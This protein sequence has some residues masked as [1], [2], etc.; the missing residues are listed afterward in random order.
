MTKLLP[1][2]DLPNGCRKISEM[3]RN[4]ICFDWDAKFNLPPNGQSSKYRSP[5]PSQQR[6]KK[7]VNFEKACAEDSEYSSIASDNKNVDFV[8]SLSVIKSSQ[9]RR[10]SA[11]TSDRGV[12]KLDVCRLKKTPLL[13]TSPVIV[14]PTWLTASQLL[15]DFGNL[16]YTSRTLWLILS[17][18]KLLLQLPRPPRHLIPLWW[19]PLLVRNPVRHPLW[20]LWNGTLMPTPEAKRDAIRNPTLVLHLVAPH[21]PLE[22]CQHHLRSVMLRIQRSIRL[23]VPHPLPDRFP[24]VCTPHPRRHCPLGCGWRSKRHHKG[25]PQED[26]H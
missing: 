8:D 2:L 4:G 7:S 11:I 21:T 24:V 14:R 25:G 13:M 20:M 3:I 16:K 15:P 18:I 19:P 26:R 10:D 22:V 5:T 17:S 6:K 1:Y 23:N 12:T 9:K